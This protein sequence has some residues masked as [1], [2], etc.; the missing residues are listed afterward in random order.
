MNIFNLQQDEFLQRHIG[1]NEKQTNEML[2]VIGINSVD[3]LI[4]KTIPQSIRLKQPL[5][6]G[7]GMSEYEYLTALKSIASQN[8]IYKNYIGQG[9]YNTI[10]TRL[11][12]CT[13]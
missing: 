6:T 10:T 3:E 12:A 8:K 1:P 13:V 5:H 2:A 11:T 4:S 7:V 9:Y